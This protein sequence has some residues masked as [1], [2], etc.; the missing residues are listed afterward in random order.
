M[1]ILGRRG[2]IRTRRVILFGLIAAFGTLVASALPD[3]R[4]YIKISRM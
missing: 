4:R 1:G 3:L 2:V